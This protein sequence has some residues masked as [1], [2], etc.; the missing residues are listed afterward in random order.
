M[1]EDAKYLSEEDQGLGHG[2]MTYMQYLLFMAEALIRHRWEN[3]SRATAGYY[4]FT[5][6]IISSL[7]VALHCRPYIYKSYENVN[8]S[9]VA[10]YF[11][12]KRTQTLFSEG[13]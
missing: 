9:N 1:T 10:I 3:W 2:E 4:H 12:G 7:G 5:H 8:F 13:C 11:P 6:K